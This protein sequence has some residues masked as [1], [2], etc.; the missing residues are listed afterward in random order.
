MKWMNLGRKAACAGALLMAG[1]LGAAPAAADEIKIGLLSPYSGTYAWWGQEYDRGVELFLDETGG[2]VGNHTIAVVKRDEGGTSPARSRQLAQELVV[3]DKV[4]YL[5]GGAF[6]P[7]I[8]GTADI[9]N[10]T[11]TPYLMGNTGTSSVTDKSPY[12]VRM[13][14]TQW[15]LNIP[16]TQWAYEQG[17]R[18]A[19]I[20]AADFASGHDAI[21]AYTVGFEEAGLF[22]F[23]D[24]IGIETEHDVCLG[25]LA[26]QLQTCQQSHAI[27]DADKIDGAVAGALKGFLDLGA[28]TPFGNEAFI[29]VDGQHLIGGKRRGDEADHGSGY[30]A[31]KQGNSRGSHGALLLHHH[32]CRDRALCD[33]RV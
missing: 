15:Q 14:F 6:T 16:L 21:K 30:A 23:I 17:A 4:Q 1:A 12:F 31:D 28:W 32:N 18:E 11:K 27:G 29:G 24:K 26:F 25:R 10:Q 22:G 19:V 8:M 13:G 3:R 5:I 20:V 7:T 9:V 2:K 33:R